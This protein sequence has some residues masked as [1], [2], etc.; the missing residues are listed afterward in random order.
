[1]AQKSFLSNEL[2]VFPGFLFISRPLISLTP[3]SIVFSAFIYYKRRRVPSNYPYH[4][5]LSTTTN[6]FIAAIT[7]LTS[8]LSLEPLFIDPPQGG[9]VANPHLCFLYTPLPLTS[10]SF[11]F[12]HLFYLSSL[13]LPLRHLCHLRKDSTQHT[14]TDHHLTII[15]Y[16]TLL[17]PLP[18]PISYQP[19]HTAAAVTEITLV[20]TSNVHITSAVTMNVP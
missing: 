17:L 8:N 5:L 1:M 19:H 13:V 7:P 15:A 6:V 12:L 10:L 20:A 16:N 2:K 14:I 3:T 18:L 4:R 11:T 9:V